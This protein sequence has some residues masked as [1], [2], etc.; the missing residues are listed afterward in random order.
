MIRVCIIAD[1]QA[2]CQSLCAAGRQS[3]ILLMTIPADKVT[4]PA[5]RPAPNVEQQL[6]AGC[7]PALTFLY[8]IFAFGFS[9]MVRVVALLGGIS[10]STNAALLLTAV[11]VAPPLGLLIWRTGAGRARSA[12]ILWSLS[13]IFALVMIPLAWIPP[14][15][16]QLL[17]LIRVALA[18]LYLGLLALYLRRT[19]PERPAAGFATMP[20]ALGLAGLLALPWLTLGALGSPLDLL[21]EVA[22]G[23]L[24]GWCA[25][26]LVAYYPLQAI[27]QGGNGYWLDAILGGLVISLALFFLVVNFG[28]HGLSP[29]LIIVLPPLAWAI[30][31]LGRITSQGRPAI[32]NRPA[33]TLLVGLAI[34]LPLITSDSETLPMEHL[35]SGRETIFYALVSAGLTLL[36]SPLLFL[37]IAVPR[38]WWQQQLS[39]QRAALWTGAAGLWLA[40]LFS[41]VLFGQPGL[42]G[43]RLFVILKDQAD[44]SAA[45]EIADYDDRRQF[46]YDTLVRHA[47]DSQADLRGLLDRFYID[48]T[49]YYLE[50]AIEVSGGLPLRVLLSLHPDVDRVLLSPM[51]RP[52]PRRIMPSPGVESAPQE[53]LWNLEM[54]GA[55]RVWEEFNVRGQGIVVGQSDSGVQ[56]T[57]PELADSYR[58]VLPDG[59]IDNDY[60]W[61]DPWFGD[62]FP[63]DDFGH[64]TH[65]LATAVGNTV[66]V[67]PD[68]GWIACKNLAR[69]IG[70][71][72]YYLDCLQFML[73]P[74][75]QDGDPWSDGDPTRSAHVLNNSWGCPAD[76]E[77]CDPQA[78]QPAMEALRSA[79]IFV[80]VAAGNDGPEC[81]SINS[82]PAIYD[83][84]FSAGA[85]DRFGRVVG[86]SSVGP[87]LVD[88]SMRLKP[89]IVAPGHEILSAYPRNSYYI[90][91]G[92]SMAGPHVAGV[93]ALL[94]SANPALIGDIAATEAILQA[95]AQPYNPDLTPVD[96]MAELEDLLLTLGSGEVCRDITDTSVI[97]N[98]ITGY[99]VLDAYRAVQMALEDN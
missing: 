44:V 74:Y 15:E 52:L 94:W 7:L 85:V 31:A 80:V 81:S 20:L 70:N 96:D 10:L 99:G 93:V 18:A 36:L 19:R 64:G 14:V 67:A 41:Y 17:A 95:S 38:R 71:I 13:I 45:G 98:N 5:P 27:E 76:M 54:L 83:S 24:L 84:V 28:P 58:G 25:A 90:A 42:Y 12:Y 53:P 40:G 87:V 33:I 57:H 60:A 43:D 51:L 89:D 91:S 22:G 79:G 65:T 86:F 16:T 77:G 32:S 82:A 61:L 68:A 23:L 59:E 75:P 35:F 37:M 69:G 29:L 63:T 55:P 6:R 34:V 48:Y 97:P 62:S 11:M 1:G 78:L 9:Q 21:L 88:G 56:L 66:G 39:A 46:V 30:L 2:D 50:N 47:R 73:A 49:P 26:L 8:I 3:T 4:A 72:G 92:T